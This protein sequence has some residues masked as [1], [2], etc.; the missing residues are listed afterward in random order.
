M[1]LL[2]QREA[3]LRKRISPQ[4]LDT[5]PELLLRADTLKN[6]PHWLVLAYSA[7]PYA[8]MACVAYNTNVLNT[9]VLL[10][11]LLAALRNKST[12]SAVFAGLGAYL[13]VYPL[14]L[15]VPILLCE[16]TN[17]NSKQSPNQ[18]Q[19]QSEKQEAEKRKK[20]EEAIDELLFGRSS[21]FRVAFVF[22]AV[23]SLLV[24]LSSVVQS[25]VRTPIA[26]SAAIS[27]QDASPFNALKHVYTFIFTVPDLRPN[28]GLFWYFFTE[29]F[30]HFLSFFLA[31]FQVQIFVYAFPLAYKFR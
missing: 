12:T 5:Q 2:R 9:I 17:S 8:I 30:E 19:N 27:S 14:A 15:L 18:Q 31:V 24:A 10:S 16:S 11:S 4:V 28:I 3:V 13:T 1:Q 20:T 22:F 7:N 6:L 23:L 21:R 29:V 26:R 25:Y